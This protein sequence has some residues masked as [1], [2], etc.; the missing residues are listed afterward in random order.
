MNT[1]LMFV[2]AGLVAVAI[3]YTSRSLFVNRGDEENPN[4]RLSVALGIGGAV[5]I[6]WGVVLLVL[7]EP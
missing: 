4:R 3:S 5:A 7:Y 6:A 1:G 2:L